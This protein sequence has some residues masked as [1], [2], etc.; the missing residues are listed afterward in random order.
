MPLNANNPIITR[1]C[2]F[3]EYMCLLEKNDLKF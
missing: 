3:E 2:M 1:F